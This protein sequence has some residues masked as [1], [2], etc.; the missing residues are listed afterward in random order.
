MVCAFKHDKFTFGRRLD[1]AKLM[2]QN[3]NYFSDYCIQK[4]TKIERVICKKIN[5]PQNKCYNQ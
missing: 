5:F 4:K 2:N 1:F 3:M